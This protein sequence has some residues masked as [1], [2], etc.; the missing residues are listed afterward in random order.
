MMREAGCR[1]YFSILS[2]GEIRDGIGFV[3][4]ANSEF[5]PDEVTRRL[6]LQPFRAARMGMPRRKGGGTFPFSA[7]AGCLQEEPALDGEEQCLRIVRTLWSRIPALNQIRREVDVE[8]GIKIVPRVCPGEQP[9]L[10]FSREIIEFCFHTGTEISVELETG[11][12]EP[13]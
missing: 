8:L 4:N 7:W 3:P 12:E 13:E 11:G 1:S 2:S 5:D 6:G 9:V 10:W